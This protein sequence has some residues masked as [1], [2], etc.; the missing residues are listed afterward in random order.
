MNSEGIGLGLMISKT[1]IELIGGQFNIFSDGVE[2]GSVFSFTMQMP[3]F[4]SKQSTV[5]GRN[6]S[7]QLLLVSQ[8][9]VSI[10]MTPK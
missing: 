5:R 6:D 9:D 4:K 10:E 2:Q 1:L 3:M 8:D 7:C